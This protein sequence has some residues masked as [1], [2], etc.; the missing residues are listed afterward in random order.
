MEVIEERAEAFAVSPSCTETHY[1]SGDVQTGIQE[2]RNT[3]CPPGAH[4][5]GATQP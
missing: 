4:G 1:V 5:Q 2:G 3:S